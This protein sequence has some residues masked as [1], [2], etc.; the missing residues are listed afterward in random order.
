MIHEMLLASVKVG[1]VCDS[2]LIKKSRMY[3]FIMALV[4]SQL[5]LLVLLVQLKHVETHQQEE[6]LP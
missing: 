4:A 5:A 6:L 2:G 1:R 3:I